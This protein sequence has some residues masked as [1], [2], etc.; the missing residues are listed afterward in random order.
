MSMITVTFDLEDKEEEILKSVL[1]NLNSV[2]EMKVTRKYNGEYMFEIPGVIIPI[3]E[4]SAE[5]KKISNIIDTIFSSLDDLREQWSDVEPT[6][7]EISQKLDELKNGLIYTYQ[8]ESI[9]KVPELSLGIASLKES[10]FSFLNSL[11]KQAEET[12][13]EEAEEAEEETEEGVEEETEEGAEE[14][15]EGVEEETTTNEI[16]QRRN[17]IQNMRNM[18]SGLFTDLETISNKYDGLTLS[19]T[20]VVTKM[21]D[22]LPEFIYVGAEHGN[23]L[24]GEVNLDEITE[25]SGDDVRYKSVFRLIKLAKLDLSNL[26]TLISQ[27]RR[28]LSKAAE[29]VTKIL[30][31]VW[32]Q[33]RVKISLELAGPDEKQLRIWISSDGGPDRF[34]EYQSYGFRWYLEFYLGYSLGIEKESKNY[35]LLLDE[36]GIHLHPFAQRNLVEVLKEIATKNQ[37][38]YTTHHIDMLDLEN[39]ERWRVVENNESNGKGTCIINEAY[40][41][42]EDHIGFEVIMKSLWGS[43]I[44]PSLIIGPRSLIVEGPSDIILLGI[45]SRILGKENEENAVLVNGEIAILQT[46]GLNYYRRMLTFCNR[47]GLNTV[48]LFDSDEAGKRTKLPLISGGIIAPNKTIEI[49]DAYAEGSVEERDL[50]NIFN[51]NILKEA[52][53]LVYKDELPSGFNFRKDD[54]PQKGGLGKRFKEFFKSQGIEQYDK[55]KVA[56]AIKNILIK[57]PGKL[58]KNSRERFVTLITKIRESFNS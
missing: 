54:L 9:T 41:P 17:L 44:V 27:R 5:T 14:E 16:S 15:E 58:P 55:T 39:P 52:T 51:F 26:P 20:D 29:N 49:N 4:I 46:G 28:I 12:E 47:P 38:I 40:K 23:L 57:E 56:E 24:K 3:D 10:L 11:T 43:T 13:E 25:A 22:M 30:Q 37:V 6:I 7:N 33:Q 8:K 50:E 21:I 1:P 34:P 35:V 19:S 42:Q 48:A 53:L 45:V 2:K 18:Y 31:K 36:P 32:G